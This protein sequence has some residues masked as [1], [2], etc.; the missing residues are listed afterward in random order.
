MKMHY[1]ALGAILL[2]GGAVAEEHLHVQK[3]G[4]VEYYGSQAAIAQ[5]GKTEGDLPIAE[6]SGD[7]ATFG[8]GACNHLD[9]EITIAESQPYVTRVRDDKFIMEHSGDGKA[10]FGAWTKNKEWNEV[11]VP[12]EVESY[13]DLQRFVRDRAR[14]A[15]VDT[16]STPFPFLLKG[17]PAYVKWH[18]NVNRTD[19]RPM[20]RKLFARSKEFYELEEE[21]VTIVGFYSEKHHGQFIGTYSPAIKD[22][23]VKNAI[24][25]HVVS[26]DGDAAG[27]IDDVKFDGGMTLFLPK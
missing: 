27:H 7:N 18:I 4:L 14:A 16:S 12:A 26:A 8:V 10:I 19:G 24:H 21:K 25:I 5:S 3:D 17:K 15:G 22:K 6:M 9:G 11:A 23:D 20:R 13:L 2:A 1:L